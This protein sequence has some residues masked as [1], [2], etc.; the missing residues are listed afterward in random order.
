MP[1][2]VEVPNVEKDLRT[3]SVCGHVS[4]PKLSNVEFL[5]KLFEML[6]NTEL[7]EELSKPWPIFG[8]CML[9]LKTFFGCKPCLRDMETVIKRFP[10]IRTNHASTSAHASSSA[11]ASAAS[12]TIQ[13]TNITNTLR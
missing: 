1:S 13:A 6:K 7:F 5:K 10:V 4:G 9:I 2:C 12:E 8:S 11:Q 3:Q